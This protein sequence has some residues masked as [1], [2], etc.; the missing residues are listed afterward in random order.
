[1]ASVEVKHDITV[2][3]NYKLVTILAL[4]LTMVA[5]IVIL[6]LPVT[7]GLVHDMALYV[8]A[9]TVINDVS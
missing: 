4:L 8:D 6:Y 3:I 5:V 2:R 9:D 1:M 7:Y